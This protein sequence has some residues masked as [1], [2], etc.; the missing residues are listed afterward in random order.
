MLLF[1]RVQEKLFTADDTSEG[2]KYA[3]RHVFM[4]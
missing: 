3:C 4:L 1:K 2:M